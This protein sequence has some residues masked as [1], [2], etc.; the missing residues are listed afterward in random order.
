MTTVRRFPTTCRPP[1]WARGGH[2]QTILGHILPSPDP[3]LSTDDQARRVEVD[4]GGDDRLVVFALPPTGP[5]TGV[6]VHLF[7]GL[8]GDTDSDYMRRSAAHLRAAGH[9]V[10]AVNH[11]GCGVGE[12]LASAPY[13]SG[14]TEDMQAVLAASR[15]EAPERTHVVAG[16]SLS[17]N[18]ALL[19]AARGFDPA[20]DAIVAINP[21]VDLFRATEDMNRG[22][23]RLYQLRFIRRLRRAVK[24]RERLGTLKQ[25]YTIPLRS[26]MLEFDDLFTAPECGFESGLDYYR[27]CSSGP[28]LDAITTPTVIVTAADDP[29]VSPEMFDQ[30]LARDV[31]LHIEPHGGH[32][33][34]VER[35]AGAWVRWLDA[36]LVWYVDQLV[37]TVERGPRSPSPS[38]RGHSSASL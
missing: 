5:P 25:S 35:Q 37:A 19:G 30:E 20:P 14:K 31:F 11:R 32:V 33:G 6:R 4:L 29:F 28:H 7:H 13:H 26:T 16:F 15:T 21:P 24:K 22:V 2:A 3:A 17:G 34:Y 1:F 36:A 27:Q 9:E 8:S 18:M 12:G 38:E 23:C 10:W